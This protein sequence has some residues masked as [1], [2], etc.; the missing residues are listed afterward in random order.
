M[1]AS[2]KALLERW[3]TRRDAEAFAEIVSRYAGMVYGTCRRI[4]GDTAIAEDVTQEC[5][6]KLSQADP[7]AGQSLGGWLHKVATNRSLNRIKADQRRHERE[8]EYSAMAHN[9]A[10]VT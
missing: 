10:E 7:A 9:S 4:L 5:F 1:K 2:N 8:K 3:A 6:M